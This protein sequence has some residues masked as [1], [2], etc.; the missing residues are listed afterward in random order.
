MT[1]AKLSRSLTTIC[2]VALLTCGTVIP[3][4]R[5]L[6]PT[7]ANRAQNNND[8]EEKV[9]ALIARMTLEEKLGQLQQLGDD[10]KETSDLIR[11][12]TS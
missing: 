8:V 10:T 7:S 6:Q 9:S 1:L 2:L 4:K 12:A 5:R 3:Q 11:S